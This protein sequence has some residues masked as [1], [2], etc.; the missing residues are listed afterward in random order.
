[1]EP[2]RLNEF[3][4]LERLTGTSGPCDTFGNVCLAHNSEFELKNVEFSIVRFV[5][6]LEYSK[7]FIEILQGKAM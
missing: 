4:W 5:K 1:M 2:L 7:A 3:L 6:P